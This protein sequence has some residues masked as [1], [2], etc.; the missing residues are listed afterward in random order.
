[1]KLEEFRD[2]PRGTKV[3]YTY[4]NRAGKEVGEVREFGYIGQTGCV[5]L[6]EEGECNMQDAIAAKPERC[7][8]LVKR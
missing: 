2:M 5:I 3:I 1:M 6:Y 7:T 4:R 8:P